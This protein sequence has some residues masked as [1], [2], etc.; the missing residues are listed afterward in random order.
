MLRGARMG[1][2]CWKPDL[3]SGLLGG[4]LGFPT[5]TWG[6]NPQPDPPLD[7]AWQTH[8]TLARHTF[9]H[10]HLELTIQTVT[11]ENDVALQRG[12]F[13]ETAQFD[14]KNLPTAMRKVY[15]QIA[16][17]LRHD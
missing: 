3:T 14:P 8:N 9:T 5:T 7:A 12:Y 4:M 1:R 13:V 6:D 17:T 10:F 16:A 15:E 11:V 2:G